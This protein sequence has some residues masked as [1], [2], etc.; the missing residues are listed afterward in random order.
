MVGLKSWNRDQVC[1]SYRRNTRNQ[2]SY[3]MASLPSAKVVSSRENYFF[4]CAA[5]FEISSFARFS[6]SSIRDSFSVSLSWT[7]F[8][9]EDLSFR[10]FAGFIEPV[11]VDAVW[12]DGPFDDVELGF[13]LVDFPMVL[14]MKVEFFKSDEFVE[15]VDGLICVWICRR[16]SSEFQELVGEAVSLPIYS[17]NIA[18]VSDLEH[19]A[20]LVLS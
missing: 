4:G 13:V 11:W 8:K 2:V 19:N 15:I 9:A 20:L 5:Y 7:R 18:H 1:C 3:P 6:S 16:T 17:R 12:A 14:N 10:D